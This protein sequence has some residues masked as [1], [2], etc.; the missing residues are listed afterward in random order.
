MIGV[1]FIA[2]VPKSTARSKIRRI[3]FFGGQTR[4]V[5]TAPQMH[6]ASV[7]LADGIGGYFVDQ[8]TFAER[9]TD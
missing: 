3:E 8:F 6:D 1:P 9:A 5:E 4:L 7:G 2:V